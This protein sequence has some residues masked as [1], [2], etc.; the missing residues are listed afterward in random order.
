[1]SEHC[2]QVPAMLALGV[3][4]WWLG[5]WHL[6]Q[7]ALRRTDDEVRAWNERRP[8]RQHDLPKR[9]TADAE[10]AAPSA[11]TPRAVVAGRAGRQGSDFVGERLRQSLMKSVPPVAN[12]DFPDVSKA[13]VAL[14][15]E[16][17]RLLQDWH[18]EERGGTR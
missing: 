12:G 11:P 3:L 5:R 6:R 13:E 2:I 17:F 18:E 7:R 10:V 1:M 9:S 16:Q 4:L 15:L 14:K 8:R